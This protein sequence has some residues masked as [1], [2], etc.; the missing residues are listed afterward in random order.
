MYG[1]DMTTVELVERL[2]SIDPQG[3]RQVY[4]IAE[5]L[6][7]VIETDEDVRLDATDHAVLIGFD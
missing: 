4:V 3:T 6:W 5:G 7:G 1:V 2:K